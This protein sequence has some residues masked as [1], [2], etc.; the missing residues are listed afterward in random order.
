MTDGIGPERFDCSGLVIRA[1]HDTLGTNSIE[2][3]ESTRHVR[4]MWLAANEQEQSNF[5]IAEAAVGILA[6]IRRKYTINGE[7]TAIAG[8]I[9]IVTRTESGLDIIHANP[10]TGKVEET[11]VRSRNVVMGFI[12][13]NLSGI[14]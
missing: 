8:H 5:C 10:R 9:G 3:Q 7:L 14:D 12:A 4:D 1:V 13:I 2:H 6:V 11:P